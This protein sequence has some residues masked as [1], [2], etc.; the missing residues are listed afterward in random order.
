MYLC[1]SDAGTW[2]CAAWGKLQRASKN[3]QKKCCS[4]SLERQKWKSSVDDGCLI[5]SHII[6]LSVKSLEGQIPEVLYHLRDQ[7]V[8]DV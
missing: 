2:D 6:G 8:S 3:Y 1:M 4:T 5:A 7:G